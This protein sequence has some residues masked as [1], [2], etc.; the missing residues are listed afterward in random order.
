MVQNIQKKGN[1]LFCQDFPTFV[2]NKSCLFLY[3]HRTITRLFLINFYGPQIVI[4]KLNCLKSKLETANFFIIILSSRFFQ[5]VFSSLE[6]TT[7]SIML[8]GYVFAMM[9]ATMRT[10]CELLMIS[11]GG[12]GE[13]GGGLRRKG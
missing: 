8:V 3:F 10:L 7:L 12:G 9:L 4:H 1:K 6:L 2:L 5:F 13:G 11:G